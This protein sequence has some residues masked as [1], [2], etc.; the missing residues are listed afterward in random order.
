VN[1]A[2]TR[3]E[4]IDPALKA[5]GWGV[6]EG[7]RIR[8]EYPITLGRIEGHGKR[9]KPL[10]ADYVLEYR[11]TKLGV[12]EAKALDEELTEG[13]GQA[14]NYA[15]KLAVRFTYAT[16]GRGIYGIDMETGKERDDITHYP[17]PE[18]LWAMTFAKVN[19][20]RNRFAG[21]PFEDK[22]GSHPSRYYQDIAV[23]RVMEAISAG[24][25]QR[26][27]ARRA[28]SAGLS[29]QREDHSHDP[30]HVPEA[31]DRGG[32][33]EHPQHRAPAPGEPVA[34]KA[35]QWPRRVT[36]TSTAPS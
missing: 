31:L 11:N 25:R 12:V 27:S 34:T 29:G 17:T 18:E 6:V 4:H 9:G 13:V 21:V 2:E 32:R 23:E 16:N 28:A 19:E 8:R 35:P 3:A 7:S 10:T 30:D 24:H 33:P 1:E 20:W 14:K 22:G 36:A 15:G 26:R 5:A